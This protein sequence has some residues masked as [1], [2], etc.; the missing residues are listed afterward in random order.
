MSGSDPSLSIFCDGCCNRDTAGSAWASVTD[1][2]GIDIVKNY[3]HLFKDLE[4]FD[5]TTSKGTYT[6]AEV[7]FNDVKSQQVNGAELLGMIMSLRI[8]LHE[9][10]MYSTLGSDSNTIINFWSLNRVN[11][12]TAQKMDPK[13]RE[14]IKECTSLR[15]KFERQL[16]GKIVKVPGASN[17]ADL[18]YHK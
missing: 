10:K 5:V 18:G 7:K 16:K 6:I 11:V 2:H 3:L 12:I 13:K 17:P 14:Y 15:K 8:L 1:E 4:L 9:A